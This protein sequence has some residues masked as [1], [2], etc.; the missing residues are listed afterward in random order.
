MPAET[1]IDLIDLDPFPLNCVETIDPITAIR[2]MSPAER[3]ECDEIWLRRDEART[4]MR[5]TIL[6]TPQQA[7]DYFAQTRRIENGTEYWLTSDLAAVMQNFDDNPEYNELGHSL[8]NTPSNIRPRYPHRIPKGAFS[9]IGLVNDRHEFWKKL[10]DFNEMHYSKI[11]GQDE[12][13]YNYGQEIDAKLT[14][15][16]LFSCFWRESG[17]FASF[18]TSFFLFP[19]SDY[20]SIF[21]EYQRLRRIRKKQSFVWA[22]K[23]FNG[24]LFALSALVPD[25]QRRSQQ[26]LNRLVFGYEFPATIKARY[27]LPLNERDP[28]ANWYSCEMLDFQHGLMRGLTRK[29][30]RI[31]A[32]YNSK[33]QTKWKKKYSKVYFKVREDQIAELINNVFEEYKSE[34]PAKQNYFSESNYIDEKKHFTKIRRA[35]MNYYATRGFIREI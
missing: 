12:R 16:T 30:M 32:E 27:N 29:V 18:A 22:E 4:I 8:V 2:N 10:N 7:F 15:Y 13:N 21:S 28:L 17:D 33:S 25:I 6:R 19:G 31:L 9:D 1:K 20:E 5:E 24:K 14:R 34:L 26:Q 23:S 11:L 35:F 3:A